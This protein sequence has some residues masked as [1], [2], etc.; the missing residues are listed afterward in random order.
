MLY[1]PSQFARDQLLTDLLAV[2][3]RLEDKWAKGAWQMGDSACLVGT[4]QLV[5]DQ[6]VGSI[7][8]PS[9][10]TDAGQVRLGRALGAI[11]M[12]L[13]G[14]AAPTNISMK[15]VMTQIIHFNDNAATHGSVLLLV[16]R[17][18]Q[19]IHA[20]AGATVTARV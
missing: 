2:R 5:T 14:P 1:S 8:L 13:Y 12:A 19:A 15:Q 6:P 20:Q 10:T 3:Q 18:I 9:G 16:D 4:V 17:A 11:Y 7:S